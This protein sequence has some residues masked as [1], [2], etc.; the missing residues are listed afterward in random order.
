MNANAPVPLRHN[1]TMNSPVSTTWKYLG[2]N[3]K[4]AYKQLFIQLTRFGPVALRR[5][6][7]GHDHY[8]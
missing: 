8:S 4:S 3:P 6:K 2:P 7:D 1:S 5:C